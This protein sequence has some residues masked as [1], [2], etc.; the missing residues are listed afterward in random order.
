MGKEKQELSNA[1]VASMG[2]RGSLVPL[3][4]PLKERKLNN[5]CSS[6]VPPLASEMKDQ[7]QQPGLQY[8]TSGHVDLT[9][10]IE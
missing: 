5:L 8:R 7:G 10:T 6:P 9:K 2:G 4:S 1:W 3:A